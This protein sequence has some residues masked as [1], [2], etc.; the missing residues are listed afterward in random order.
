M[1]DPARPHHTRDSAVLR[2]SDVE[3]FAGADADWAW[4]GSTGGGVRVAVIDSGIEHD[5]PL[6]EGCVDVEAGVEVLVD[7]DGTARV[8]PGPHDDVYGHGTACAGIIHSMAPEARITSVRVL[9]HLNTGKAAGFLHGLAWAVDQGFDVINLS[10]GTTRQ[11]WALPFYELCDRAYFANSFLVTAAN[12]TARPSFPS[13][14]A[15]VTS[16]ACN[17]ATDPW[18]FHVSPDPPTEF[19]ARG[20]DVEVAWKGGGTI[21][22]TGNSFAAPHITALAALVRAKH[23]TLRPFQVKALLWAAAANVREAPRPAGRFS[24]TLR[25]A[26]VSLPASAALR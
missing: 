7:D 26:T 10:L 6:L 8:E 25:R 19:L 4:G 21:T 5:H 17:L 1:A 15:S 11:E 24:A 3:S 20:I 23:P 16:V 14:F 12:N 18:R 2:L 9:G 13:L 22:M